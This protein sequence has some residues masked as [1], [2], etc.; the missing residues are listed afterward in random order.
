MPAP[1]T[2]PIVGS[3]YPNKGRKAPSR[4]FAIELCETGDPI[5]LRP[6]PENEFDENAIAV[7]SSDGIQMG[8][9]PAARAPYVGMMMRRG[10]VRAVFQG[11]IQGRAF[12]RIAFDGKTPEIPMPRRPA[13]TVQ[14]WWPDEVW[15]DD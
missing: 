4:R 15:P 12:A 5:E 1:I 14:E 2:L 8:Y 11:Q 3:Q 7:F 9:L 10:E 6:E 13:S